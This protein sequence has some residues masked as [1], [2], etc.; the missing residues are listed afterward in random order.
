MHQPKVDPCTLA[1]KH[2]WNVSGVVY[3]K[4]KIS[5]RKEWYGMSARLGWHNKDSLHTSMCK[6]ILKRGAVFPMLLLNFG[7]LYT[8]SRYKFKVISKMKWGLKTLTYPRC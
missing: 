8:L 5:Q 7:V 1:L 3:E 4:T 2:L 6:R